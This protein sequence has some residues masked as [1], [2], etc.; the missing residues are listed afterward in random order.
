MNTV[1]IKNGLAA[2]AYITTATAMGLWLIA[3]FLRLVLDQIAGELSL[4]IG[5]LFGA[6][7]VTVGIGSLLLLVAFSMSRQKYIV[8]VDGVKVRRLWKFQFIP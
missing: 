1:T 5:Q 7:L 6:S 8:S 3:C 2:Y 4:T